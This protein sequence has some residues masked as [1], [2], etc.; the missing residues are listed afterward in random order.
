MNS[1]ATIFARL[2]GDATLGALLANYTPSTGGATRKAIF[3]EFAPDDFV[4]SAAQ[5]KPCLVIAAPDDRQPSAT[6]TE[7]FENHERKV[8]GYAHFSGSTVGLDDMMER[9]V[10]LFQNAQASLSVTGGT[11]IAS[12]VAGPVG[13]PAE[14]ASLIGRR[15][16]LRLE[17]QAN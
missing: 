16:T 3:N 5:P 14:D 7:K 9:V 1:S 4:M 13:S 10:T 2:S 17:F 8:R 6:L 11:V 15:V 12:R